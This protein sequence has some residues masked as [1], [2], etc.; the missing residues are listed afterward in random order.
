MIKTGIYI[1]PAGIKDNNLKKLINLL[2]NKGFLGS[3]FGTE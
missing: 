3:L 2:S 1:N